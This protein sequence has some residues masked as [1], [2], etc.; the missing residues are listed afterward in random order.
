[1][2]CVEPRKEWNTVTLSASDKCPGD[3]L[4]TAVLLS[5]VD[6]GNGKEA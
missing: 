2:E 6:P 3:V 5:V 1:M 4:T